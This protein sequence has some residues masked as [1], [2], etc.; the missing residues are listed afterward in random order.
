M[1]KNNKNQR[2]IFKIEIILRMKATNSQIIF[3]KDFTLKK[4]HSTQTDSRLDYMNGGY[5]LFLSLIYLLFLSCGL[6]CAFFFI[7]CILLFWVTMERLAMACLLLLLLLLPFEP[8]WSGE[9]SLGDLLDEE[10]DL[11]D[12]FSAVDLESNDFLSSR[13]RF[14]EPSLDFLSSD[15]DFESAFLSF[16]FSLS[17]FPM[18]F[19]LSLATADEEEEDKEEENGEDDD[20]DEP[21]CLLLDDTF[22]SGLLDEDFPQSPL[23]F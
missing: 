21:S 12:D 1:I 5:T 16:S 17:S 22:P 20:L 6:A 10:S 2:N 23:S 11:E 14:E 7:I 19:P 3:W 15:F 9:E 8:E 18:A 13:S 4:Y